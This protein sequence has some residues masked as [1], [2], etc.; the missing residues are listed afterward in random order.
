M[1]AAVIGVMILIT[2]WASPTMNAIFVRDAMALL[3]FRGLI[4]EWIGTTAGVLWT[5]YVEFWFYVSFPF[6]L[7][8]ASYFR[9][10]WLML[11]CG[12]ILSLAAKV[13]VSEDLLYQYYDQLL[14]GAI[15]AYAQKTNRIPSLIK[16]PG[17]AKIA[18]LTIVALGLLLPVWHRNFIWYTQSLLVCCA[19]AVAI[20][21]FNEHPPKLK[22]PAVSYVGRISYSIYFVHAMILDFIFKTTDA[23]P[24]Q[25]P[26]YFLLT[27]GV[28]SFTY[29]AIEEPINN[30]AKRFLPFNRTRRAKELVPEPTG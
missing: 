19:T 11:F 28:S 30:L 8:I 24:G 7:L 23:M 22:L 29:V 16:H 17:A 2:S 6:L 9:A 27:V 10:A 14:I 26:L 5:L 1:Y 18:I 12:V 15:A 20:L 3:T 13:P 25:L 4:G 21:A